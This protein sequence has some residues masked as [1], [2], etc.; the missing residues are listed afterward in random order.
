MNL[1]NLIFI[2]LAITLILSGCDDLVKALQ[3]KPATD[4]QI[5]DNA[6]RISNRGDRSFSGRSGKEWHREK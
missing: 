3:K 6:R 4:E 1:R 5:A 2:A